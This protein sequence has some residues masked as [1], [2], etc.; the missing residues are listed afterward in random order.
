MR[1]FAKPLPKAIPSEGGS[2]DLS[3]EEAEPDGSGTNRS[4][5]PNLIAAVWPGYQSDL[6]EDVESSDEDNW[7]EEEPRMKKQRRRTLE[8]PAREAHR[9]KREKRKIEWMKGLTEIDKL[10]KSRKT[11]W[12]AGEHGVQAQR[13]RAIQSYLHLVVRN[14][15]SRINASQ[16]AAE[17]HGFSATHGGRLIRQYCLVD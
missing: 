11:Q 1:N 6:P 5:S 14:G 10:V 17:T 7:E 13:A 2:H 12:E 4:A 16:M 8:V 9:I 15:H 3:Q